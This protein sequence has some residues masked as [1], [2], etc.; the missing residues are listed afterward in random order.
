MKFNGTIFSKPQQDQLKENIGNE[1][2]KA[3]EKTSKYI[4]HE[5]TIANKLYNEFINKCTSI[6]YIEV[7]INGG[8]DSAYIFGKPS[9]TDTLAFSKI[10]LYSNDGQTREEM[11]NVYQNEWNFI[12]NDVAV[13]GA[14]TKHTFTI[15]KIIVYTK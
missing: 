14:K 1:L 7:Y 8:G 4:P 10:E 15:K 6:E 5:Y 11:V 13:N 3:I 12:Y 9:K 2:E